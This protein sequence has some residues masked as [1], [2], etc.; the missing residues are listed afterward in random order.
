MLKFIAA[1][2]TVVVATAAPAFA[3]VATDA[4]T[5]T[6]DGQTF[7]YTKVAKDDHVDIDGR[8]L[9]SGATFHLVVRGKRVAGVSNGVPVSFAV[10]PKSATVDAN[11]GTAN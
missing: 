11:G 2:A 1:V 8:N 3:D 4:R 10:P 6:R 7:T 5:F 9:T